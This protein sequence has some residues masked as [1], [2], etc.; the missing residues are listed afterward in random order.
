MTISSSRPAFLPS[1]AGGTQMEGVSITRHDHGTSGEYRAHVAGSD[2]VGRLIW[3]EE[4]GV[5]VADHTLVPP[6]IG[7]RGVAAALVEAMVADAQAEGFRILPLCSYV[8]AAFKRHPEW[9]DLRA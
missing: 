7:N 9:G 3:Y 6:E 5:K 2:H 8:V 4:D 1:S